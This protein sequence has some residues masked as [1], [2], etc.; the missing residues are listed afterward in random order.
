MTDYING[1]YNRRVPFLVRELSSCINTV[2]GLPVNILNSYLSFNQ[3]KSNGYI[4]V[5]E[6]G[7]GL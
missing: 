7:G 1:N 6:G 5:G 2:I 4:A 3:I